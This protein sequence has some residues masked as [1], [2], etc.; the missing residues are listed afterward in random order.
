M[1]CTDL[2]LNKVFMKGW[3][4]GNCLKCSSYMIRRKGGT[5]QTFQKP[6]GLSADAEKS[7]GAIH[8]VVCM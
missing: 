7:D 3:V 1:V 6:N 4:S 2:K 5:C 8:Q